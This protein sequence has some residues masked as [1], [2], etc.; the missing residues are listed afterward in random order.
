MGSN[1]VGGTVQGPFSLVLNSS[2]APL[3]AASQKFYVK[4]D[5]VTGIGTRASVGSGKSLYYD[6]GNNEIFYVN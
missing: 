6:P 4:T 5:T 2:N 3:A 1:A